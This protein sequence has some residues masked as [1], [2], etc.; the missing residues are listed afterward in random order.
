LTSSGGLWLLGNPMACMNNHEEKGRGVQAQHRLYGNQ[1]QY[2]G[3]SEL[4]T[5]AQSMY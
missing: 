4:K 3:I 5:Q 1:T 2:Q